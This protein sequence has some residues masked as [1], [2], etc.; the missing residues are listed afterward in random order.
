MA[1]EVSI[2]KNAICQCTD[3]QIEFLIERQNHNSDKETYDITDTGRST[4]ARWKKD[5]TFRNAYDLVLSAILNP[6]VEE[7]KLVVQTEDVQTL[8][9][10]QLYR[11]STQLPEMFEQLF[12]IAIK[13]KP[14]DSLRAIGIISDYFGFSSEMFETDKLTALQKKILGWTTPN[15]TDS[16]S[17]DKVLSSTTP[18][19]MAL[20][21][22][23][24][25]APTSSETSE[26]IENSICEVPAMSG[27]DS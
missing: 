25:N 1:L 8:A 5:S 7:T 3:S 12:N 21:R 2:V 6:P 27:E 22:E 9:K 26:T 17:D 23:R 11:L 20:A 13:G 4:L 10:E 14:A 18:N 15:L 19:P 16:A 24:N